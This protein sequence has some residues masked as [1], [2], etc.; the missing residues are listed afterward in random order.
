MKNSWL[1][2][3]CT[4]ERPTYCITYSISDMSKQ[5]LEF[6]LHEKG[7]LHDC[8]KKTHTK[9]TI[10]S[11]RQGWWVQ[12]TSEEDLGTSAMSNSVALVW[13]SNSVYSPV[14]VTIHLIIL[15]T[16]IIMMV[17]TDK[18]LDMYCSI[19]I[20]NQ[21]LPKI[22][23]LFIGRSERV[24]GWWSGLSPKITWKNSDFGRHFH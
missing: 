2:A 17:I 6:F 11:D 20:I 21:P 5:V 12:C 1:S 22:S 7:T 4:N 23:I 8:T 13:S 15:N 10:L 18:N 24:G 14:H 3:H 9:F 19:I 16:L